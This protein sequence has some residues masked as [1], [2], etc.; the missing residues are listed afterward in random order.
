MLRILDREYFNIIK[1]E[2]PIT[3]KNKIINCLGAVSYYRPDFQEFR[4]RIIKNFEPETFTNLIILFPCSATKPYS[5]S[6]SHK[7]FL[8]VLRKF[9][10]FP[11]FQEI[12]LTSPLGAIPRQLED[13]YPVNSYNI[14]VTGDWDEEEIKISSE[15]L[16]QLLRK[17]DEN[18]PILAHLEGMY[19]EIVTRALDRLDRNCY[20]SEFYDKITSKDSL[21]SLED[22]ILKF[23]D[24]IKE[25]EFQ[26]KE[27]DFS[28]TW[29]RKIFKILDYQFGIG[30]GQK[31]LSKGVKIDIKKDKEVVN[32]VD[33][34]NNETLGSF[35]KANGQI[36]LTIKGAQLL[37][38]F[39]DLNSNIIVFNGKEIS[40]NTL[41]R[42]GVL[43][44]SADLIPNSN[45]IILDQEKR[46]V[47]GVGNLLVGYNFIKNSSTGRVAKIYEHK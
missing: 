4:E 26:S 14:P 3:Q 10:Q 9:P 46:D 34:K 18:I 6:K 20:F 42:P 33:L 39:S 23:K 41:F 17:Y 12:I 27:S 47:I 31:I 28:K 5:V 7:K 40:G 13:I 1:F 25:S 38:P 24:F 22:N 43:H 19:N 32:I 16:F 44:Y 15:M 35:I 21:T 11:N 30:S 36:L 37:K 2:S 8:G 45:I 29:F